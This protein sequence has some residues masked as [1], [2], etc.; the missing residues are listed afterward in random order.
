[1]NK[2]DKIETFN[3]IKDKLQEVSPQKDPVDNVQWVDMDKVEGNEYNPNKVAP[4]EMK[5]LKLSINED[6]Y[7]QPIVC[8]KKDDKYEIVDG[9]HRNLIP[10]KY[11]YIRERMNGKL[12]IV[13]IE[14]DIKERMASTIRHNRAR[15]KHGVG[16][17]SDLVADLVK[18][19]WEDEDIAEQLGMDFD[20][21]LRLKQQTGLPEIFKD[22]DFS[23]S[24][25]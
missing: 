19:G 11:K 16:E 6:G 12:P 20:E 10:K 9:F 24:W 17:M 14:K 15:G 23:K 7:T 22:E 18:K 5:L 4:P 21:V 13:V 3:N 8:Y 2:E 25:R 1:M